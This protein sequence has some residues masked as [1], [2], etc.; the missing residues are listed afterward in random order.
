MLAQCLETP[1]V[2]VLTTWSL[3]NNLE[4][5]RLSHIDLTM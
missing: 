3:A 1:P 2:F 5:E 4:Y